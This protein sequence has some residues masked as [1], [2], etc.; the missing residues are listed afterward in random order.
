MIVVLFIWHKGSHTPK[1]TEEHH[2]VFCHVSDR[3]IF[4]LLNSSFIETYLPSA[5]A[6]SHS[7]LST[8][9]SVMTVSTVNLSPR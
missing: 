9:R 3:I 6:V 1:E 8:S 4:T 7:P 2:L 5:A